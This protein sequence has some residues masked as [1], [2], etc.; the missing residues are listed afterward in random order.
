MATTNI[1]DTMYDGTA[2]EDVQ[3]KG[4]EQTPP[5][6]L[7][8]FKMTNDEHIADVIARLSPTRE[9]IMR[10]TYER[11]LST[12]AVEFNGNVE[13]LGLSRLDRN[14][15]RPEQLE[16]LEDTRARMQT[17]LG[18]FANAI[19]R[20]ATQAATV[21]VD[22]QLGTLAGI[23]WQWG[24]L[25]AGNINS[26]REFR[27]ARIDNP[28]SHELQ[29]LNDKV[30]EIFR[31]YRT[32]DQ[33]E[34]PWHPGAANFWADNILANAGFVI[35]AALSGKV[36]ASAIGNVMNVSKRKDLFAKITQ[37]LK[38]AGKDVEG[39]SASKVLRGLKNGTLD[40]N[41]AEMAADLADA[42]KKMKNASITMKLAGSAIAASG[43]AR[44]ESINAMNEYD[45]ELGNPEDLR[46][47]ARLDAVNKLYEDNPEWFEFVTTNTGG[48][49]LECVN[50]DG[51]KLLQAEYDKI[52]ARYAK[53][54]D[55]AKKNREMVG[56]TVFGINMALL[57]FGDFVQFGKMFAGQY[58][59]G[60]LTAKG[61]MKKA[62][63]GTRKEAAQKATTAIDRLASTTYEGAGR[64]T[65]FKRKIM[66]GIKNAFVEGQEEMNQSWASS[67]AKYKGTNQV[68]E[69]AE[70]LRDPEGQD[71]SVKFFNALAEG[72]KQS[73]GN[74]DDYVEFFAGA[75]MGALGLPSIEMKYNS[76]TGQMKKGVVL[77]GG[78]WDAIRDENVRASLQNTAA[79]ELN[80]RL[81]DPAF[82]A[83]YYG[84]VGHN[85]TDE[86]LE[87]ALRNGDKEYYDKYN[88]MQLIS[89]M[90][91]FDDAGR[92]DDFIKMIDNL[93]TNSTTDETIA[94]V[95][96]IL[97][98]DY[99]KMDKET[100]REQISDNT[101]NIKEQV[102]KYRKV[103]KELQVLYGNTI[104]K[105]Q[106]HEMIWTTL[107]LDELN[108]QIQDLA[109]KL[110]PQAEAFREYEKKNGVQ[111]KENPEEDAKEQDVETLVS[112][113]YKEFLAAKTKDKSKQGITNTVEEQVKELR[114]KYQSRA[115]YY[116]MIAKLSN[117]PELVAKR[118]E[119]LNKDREK[120]K[121]EAET[122]AAL[123][124]LNDIRKYSDLVAYMDKGEI[125][126]DVKNILEDAAGK[127]NAQAKFVLNAP[128]IDSRVR[129]LIEEK[130]AKKYEKEEL[131]AMVADMQEAW[132]KHI[133]EAESIDDMLSDVTDADGV[134]SPE[135]LSTLND[136]IRSQRQSQASRA[137]DTQTR[138]DVGEYYNHAFGK[139]EK[140]KDLDLYISDATGSRTPL[141]N[142]RIYYV[143]LTTGEVFSKDG[144]RLG[145]AYVGEKG[146]TRLT[147]N[148]AKFEYQ[149]M[150]RVSED[151]L[152]PW[153]KG[154]G[155]PKPGGKK[156]RAEAAM[157][158]VQSE[159]TKQRTTGTSPFAKRYIN[160][161][162]IYTTT[163][164]D[165]KRVTKHGKVLAIGESDMRIKFDGEQNISVIPASEASGIRKEP[166][167]KNKPQAEPQAKQPEAQPEPQPENAYRVTIDTANHIDAMSALRREMAE[168]S[169]K[170]EAQKLPPYVRK[171]IDE[172]SEY[173]QNADDMAVY[174][175]SFGELLDYAKEHQSNPVMW[176]ILNA[177]DE[178]N[179]YHDPNN[180]PKLVTPEQVELE[181]EVEKETEEPVIPEPQKRQEAKATYTEEEAINIFGFRGTIEMPTY[182]KPEKGKQSSKRKDGS[183][184]T[185]REEK[186][187]K[188]CE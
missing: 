37:E 60:R 185:L 3:V 148:T 62:T 52:D 47:Q 137:E 166:V 150:G 30:N 15:S 159:S 110:K 65:T 119:T 61:L 51:Q 40:L 74:S 188:D 136:I 95:Q 88:H 187:T 67:L 9:D 36:S 170:E 23:E 16:D 102:E 31:N 39:L 73:W 162:V 80:K 123:K 154:Y 182:G 131:S 152:M 130:L 122:K 8:N 121:Q 180:P 112:D 83:Y 98:G 151:N 57:T 78:M 129:D 70:R 171:Y 56:N 106:L 28:L 132:R 127:G 156:A 5:T 143:D 157:A 58:E 49:Y 184:K 126:R 183:A 14:I 145:I 142:S 146:N 19:P 179:Q 85:S 167:R 141:T 64:G 10:D 77:R 42:A 155:K 91:M 54:L 105:E 43:E 50:P 111:V 158:K 116:D 86:A 34:S 75:F 6:S 113:R 134:Y 44:I 79:D 138:V 18:K 178:D 87:A 100:L 22:G 128:Q 11:T 164:D 48:K 33:R 4:E 38:E 69:F 92:L 149:S 13:G 26:Y 109:E 35:G 176:Q 93:A 160:E 81:Q 1:S 115:D 7:G 139:F 46:L 99:A 20:M 163:D 181:K 153:D 174:N 172:V 29:G 72:W 177:I 84:L 68:G 103:S 55:D 161:R 165:G 135:F 125:T 173:P 17:P 144:E 25:A 53:Y 41:S 147:T 175:S 12:P 59:T 71:R 120:D 186:K 117:D 97:G 32:V 104:N 27:N 124:T 169:L 94:A 45:Q 82:K 114:Q 63:D 133:L 101:K 21:F 89:D 140:K 96:S 107:H 66:G 118:M 168:G 76:R 2:R 90:I 24:Q 108:K